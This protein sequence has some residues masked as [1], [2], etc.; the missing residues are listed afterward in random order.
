KKKYSNKEV[1]DKKLEGY[2]LISKNDTANIFEYRSTGFGNFKNLNRLESA[3]NE[4]RRQQIAV[5][6]GIPDSVAKS[7]MKGVSMNNVKVTIAGQEEEM[8]FGK[9]FFSSF[10]GIIV[11]FFVLMT[12]GG[13]LIRSL[14]EEKSNRLIEIIVSSCK[15][16][17]LML[18][19]IIGLTL[20]VLTQL[21]VW[22]LLGIAAAGG[23]AVY[24]ISIE[25]LLLIL[26]YFISG[27]F[28][29]VAIFVGIGS[30]VSTEQEAQ[31]ITG[32]MSM[33]LIFPVVILVPLIQN[34]DMMI[35]KVLSYF[36]LTTTPF[37][38]VRIN[39]GSALWWEHLIAIPL[40]FL[41]V[42]VMVKISAKIFRI[43]ILSYGKMP[44]LKEIINWLKYAE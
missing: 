42:L 24:I 10:I 23:A 21:A 34:P 30:I 11:L 9:Q 36:P 1:L 20:L 19:K 32:Y 15:S 2:L 12:M 31:Q 18:G 35:V 5:S 44:G 33:L 43:G 28:L 25:N 8:D 38:M 27:F 3:F 7:I 29:Y 6:A 41:S 17:E 26:T 39:L 4:I 13:T 22:S 40:M 14:L 37:M 16:S